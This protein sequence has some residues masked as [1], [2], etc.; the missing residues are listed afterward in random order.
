MIDSIDRLVV[1]QELY[2]DILIELKSSYDYCWENN[3]SPI[4]LF[5]KQEVSL[6]HEYLEKQENGMSLMSHS[7]YASIFKQKLT[8]QLTTIQQQSSHDINHTIAV[9]T[10]IL[11][12]EVQRQLYH[13]AMPFSIY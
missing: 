2:N 3:K 1:C 10:Q 12:D 6:F 13:L 11:H 4:Q 8:V 7:E 5:L 9:V